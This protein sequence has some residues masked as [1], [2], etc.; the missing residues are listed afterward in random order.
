MQTLRWI[1][2]QGLDEIEK[3]NETK[4]SLLYNEIDNNPLFEGTAA[5]E[6]RSRMNVTFLLKDSNKDEA[7]LKACA[8]A[9]IS[10]IKGHRSV[11]GFRASMYN[12]LG[13]DSVQALVEVMKN[14]R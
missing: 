12:A 1:D 6:D 4:A 8:D 3:I 5:T 7:F 2:K 9:N 10:G 11:G 13:L 14:F